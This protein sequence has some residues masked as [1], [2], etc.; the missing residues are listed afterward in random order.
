MVLKKIS[1]TSLLSLTAAHEH[2]AIWSK[3]ELRSYCPCRQIFSTIDA[4]KLTSENCFT[5]KSLIELLTN[6]PTKAT[7]ISI[8]TLALS[9]GTISRHRDIVY[10]ILTTLLTQLDTR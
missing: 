6:L 1:S 9:S 5:G 8:R 10:T 2:V 3:F 7:N 4:M